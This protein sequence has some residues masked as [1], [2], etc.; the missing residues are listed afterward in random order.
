MILTKKPL[1]LSL[2]GVTF[3]TTKPMLTILRRSLA[4]IFFASITLLFLDFTGATHA[5]LSWMAEVQF[6]PAVLA[7][8][9]GVIISLV[10][11]TLL[12]GRIYCS[13]IC[14][15]GVMQDV[16]AKIGRKAKKNRYS[17]SKPLTWLRLVML[18]L[19]VVGLVAGLAY[20]VALL[21]PYGAYGRIAQNLFAP[22]WQWGNNLLASAAQSMDSYAFYSVDVWI[23]SLP[24]F[25]VAALTFVVVVAL[26][27]RNGR[28]YCNSICPVGTIL[29]YVSKFSLF[30]VKLNKDKCRSCTLCEK[31]CKSACIDTKTKSI[32]YSRC[33][34]CFKCIGKCKFDAMSYG[35]KFGKTAPQPAASAP[36]TKEPQAANGANGRKTFIV[37]ALLLGASAVKAQIPEVVDINLD[38][39]LAPL[40]NKKSPVRENRITPPGSISHKNFARK[41]TG[42]QLCVTVCPEGVLCPSS[43]LD[44][45]MQP[46]LSFLK[47]YCRPGCTKCS[48]VCPSDAIDKIT[49]AEKSAISV[50]KAIRLDEKCL[51]H[52]G[53]AECRACVEQCPTQA[54]RMAKDSD[55]KFKPAKVMHSKCTGCG[56]CEYVCP[57]TPISAIVVEGSP[58]HREI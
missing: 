17:Y 56:V 39:G 46:E 40:P 45:F 32:D 4:F 8:N 31:N 5:W 20:I 22:L 19:A 2:L 1:S 11:L 16:A 53:E 30:G 9:L 13:V 44:T 10:L 47:G 48:E 14:P 12:F 3:K 15:L 29:G 18:V 49:A 43:K 52:T 24:V 38:G 28:T 57:V 37:S 25:V 54:I 21:D 7:I 33:V 34:S 41:C 55:G 36:Q 42:C 50:G 6:V 51:A 23:R 58:R 26:A 27:Y 35:Y